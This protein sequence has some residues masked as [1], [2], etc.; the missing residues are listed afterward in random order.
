MRVIDHIVYN[1]E[2][3]MLLMRMRCLDPVVDKFHIIEGDF[4]FTGK[5]KGFKFA[6]RFMEDKR[7][8]EFGKKIHLSCFM[9]GESVP[10]MVYINKKTSWQN[11]WDTRDELLRRAKM[12]HKEG[13][14]HILSDV[15]EIPSRFAVELVKSAK[16]SGNIKFPIVSSLNYYYYDFDH[17]WK[18]NCLCN[19]FFTDFKRSA[20]RMRKYR[21]RYS[22]IYGGWH[23]SYFGGTDTVLNKIHSFAHTELLDGKRNTKEWVESCISKGIDF[24]G[25]KKRGILIQKQNNVESLP[26][27]AQE[28]YAKYISKT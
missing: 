6:S 10:D 7:F 8:N 23:C 15:D 22:R 11:E 20:K 5:Y 12:Y 24:I 4:S 25:G 16:E 1:D 14:I 13:D 2:L 17:Q 27:Y 3:D 26:D 19:I 21:R 28:A 18:D 9:M